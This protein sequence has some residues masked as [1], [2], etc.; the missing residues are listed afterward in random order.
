MIHPTIR[1]NVIRE[2]V[3]V[4]FHVF[5]DDL[6]VICARDPIISACVVKS[7]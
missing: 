4:S 1:D 7:T 2:S 6:I 5:S 3:S